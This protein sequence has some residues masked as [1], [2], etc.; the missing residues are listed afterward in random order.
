MF[1]LDTN[2][3]SE[4]R[5]AKAEQCGFRWKWHSDPGFQKEKSRITAAPS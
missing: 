5:K 2:V 4:L 1:V 3:I